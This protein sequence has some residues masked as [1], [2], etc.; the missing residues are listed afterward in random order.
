MPYIHVHLVHNYI[1]DFRWNWK[2]V[3]SRLYAKENQEM[4]I[5]GILEPLADTQTV[6]RLHSR[7]LYTQACSI[8]VVVN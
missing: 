5:A 2:F 4:P 1:P 8:A 7:I 6:P 3:I